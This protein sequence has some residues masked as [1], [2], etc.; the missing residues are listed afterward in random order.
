M[1][2]G[3]FPVWI[4]V[5]VVGFIVLIALA[6]LNWYLPRMSRL[7]AQVMSEKSTKRK[8]NY[9]VKLDRHI[10]DEKYPQL[11][12]LLYVITSVCFFVENHETI[13]S[14]DYL[15]LRIMISLGIWLFFALVV[16]VFLVG[17]MGVVEYNSLKDVKKYYENRYGVIV[18]HLDDED[19]EQY[20]ELSN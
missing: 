11:A 19:I 7:K 1:A 16:V 10:D 2:I 13:F 4:I 18:T 5:A 6:S 8:N 20:Y 17:L 3:S 14:G 15:L 12:F 9:I